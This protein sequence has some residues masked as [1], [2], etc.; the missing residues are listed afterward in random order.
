MTKGFTT[1]FT[2]FLCMF[3]NSHTKKKIRGKRGVIET[4]GLHK[5]TMPV[6]LCQTSLY[7]S[8]WRCPPCSCPIAI[9]AFFCLYSISKFPHPWLFSSP[10]LS[11]LLISFF[12]TLPVKTLSE[13]LITLQE[14]QVQKSRPGTRTP[15][16][17][18]QRRLCLHLC[19]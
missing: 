1:L 6:P 3:K 11:S 10:P 12:L 13:A 7:L 8:S 18:P 16:F 15:G 19:N 17:Q 9:A 4:G 14:D 2:T 5:I